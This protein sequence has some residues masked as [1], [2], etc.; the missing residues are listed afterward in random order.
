MPLWGRND[1]A[2]TANSTTT[3]E[4]S[5]GAP[6][7]LWK[8]IKGGKTGLS[9]NAAHT[10]NANFGNTS[11]GSRANVDV[12]LFNNATP[13]ALVSGQAVGVFGVSATEM[14]NNTLNSSKEIPAHAGWNLR[15]AGTGPIISITYTG[16][17]T[18]YSNTDQ[19]IVS[20]PVAGGNAKIT[21]TTNTTGGALTNFTVV[22]PGF[23]FL[24]TN[25][26]PNAVY[27]NS[28][29]GAT[30]TG[31]GATFNPVAGGRAGRIHYE[32]IVAMGSLGAQ[33]AASGTPATVADSTGDNTFFPGT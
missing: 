15:K 17:A 13:S 30:V 6:I 16:T 28:T 19:I 3:K 29:G 20:S 26:S 14:A 11:P 21:F 12:I 8:Y 33:T 31:S 5:N 7:G 22:T 27:A 9:A 32:T 23:G 4:T 2:V 18:G 25:A 10:A 24:N 1:Q